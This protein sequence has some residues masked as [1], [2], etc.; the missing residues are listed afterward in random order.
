ME[1]RVL[2]AI[3]LSFLVL[4]AYQ[5][6][7]VKPVPKP[8]TAPVAAGGADAP[9]E[10]TP[11]ALPPTAAQAA[12]TGRPAGEQAAAVVSAVEERDVKVE[13]QHVSAV[14]TNRCER[15]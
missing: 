7:F 3:F 13:N 10:A 4:Y 5:A 12:L 6:Y 8:G 11:V 9:A 2:I 14:W 1:R 15:L